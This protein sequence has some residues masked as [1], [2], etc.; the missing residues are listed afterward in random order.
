MSLEQIISRLD[1]H[2]ERILRFGHNQNEFITQFRQ[3]TEY[4]GKLMMMCVGLFKAL[5]S[6]GMNAP[7]LGELES[8]FESLVGT[9]TI[10][11]LRLPAPQ[12]QSVRAPIP[13]IRV[14][15]PA[16]DP[17]MI[18]QMGAAIRDL[19]TRMGDMD[20]TIHTMGEHLREAMAEMSEVAKRPPP[21]RVAPRF[22]AAEDDEPPPPPRRPIIASFD[23]DKAR[24]ALDADLAGRG[25]GQHRLSVLNHRL[26]EFVKEARLNLLYIG[27]ELKYFVQ[28]NAF[29]QTYPGFI[30]PD[31]NHHV[32]LGVC[33]HSCEP[34]EGGDFAEADRIPFTPPDTLPLLNAARPFNQTTLA[35][36]IEQQLDGTF[37]LVWTANCRNLLLSR[38]LN[39]LK[40]EPPDT[41]IFVWGGDDL[42]MKMLQMAGALIRYPDDETRPFPASSPWREFVLA[43]GTRDPSAPEVPARLNLPIL[44]A[45]PHTKLGLK[46]DIVNFEEQY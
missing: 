46:E 43:N 34:N 14:E 10:P 6:V 29:D 32:E 36:W 18:E 2:K 21:R 20:Q 22:P 23:V 33:L 39:E 44:F 19:I 17:E 11:Q 13:T 37:A 35:P 27:K 3:H 4:I 25:E 8:E 30:V 42:K 16:V 5:S 9:V 45:D 15:E 40:L 31:P 7:V 28:L 24:I 12:T 41:H 38:I 1:A 26:D